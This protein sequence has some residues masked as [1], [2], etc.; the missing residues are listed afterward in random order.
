MT[1]KKQETVA[2]AVPIRFNHKSTEFYT[3][4]KSRVDSYF[5]DNHISK[6]GTWSMFAKTILMFSLYFL[7]YGLL[8]SNVFEGKMIWLLLAAGMGIAMAGIG[9]CVMHDSNHGGFSTSNALNKFMT[10]FSM[11]LLGGHSLNWRIQHNQIHHNYT[12]I[13]EHDE[14]IAPRGILR[15]EPHSAKKPVHQLQFLYAWF[16][17]GLMTIMWCTVKDFRQV[18]RFNKQKLLTGKTNLA[19]ELAVIVLSK[20]AY[21]GYMLLPYFL[22]DEMTFLNWLTGFLLM[23]FI[24]GLGLATIFQAAHVVTE[25]EFPLP[26]SS[27]NLKDHWAEHQLRTTMNFAM[28]DKI[29]TWMIGGLNYQVE[30]HL[31]PTICHVH[32]PALSRIVART[33]S[34]FN[35]PYHHQKTFAGAIYSHGKTLYRLG[36]N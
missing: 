10:Y 11:H 9:L 20:T 32:Y 1:I 25:T 28:R 24:A 36:R 7:F 6:K 30:H 8:V 29:F 13:H 2:S 27:G 17:Y 23:H 14:D 19:K 3:V 26:D 15:F 33:A 18:I 34:E 35:L 22:T 16:F 12:N 5:K 4:L 21:F 31:F